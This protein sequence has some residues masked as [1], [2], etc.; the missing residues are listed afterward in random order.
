MLQQLALRRRERRVQV[1]VHEILARAVAEAPRQRVDVALRRRRIGERPRVLVDPERERRRLERRRREL[2]LG[3]DPDERR[4]ERAVRRQHRRLRG[5]PLGK[6]VL[7][8]VVE[9]HLLDV[10][11]ESDRFELAEPRRARH[12]DDD[13]APDRV[14]LE[15]AHLGDGAELLGVQ[16]VEVADVPV[17]RSDGDDGVGIEEARSEHRSER[18]EVGVPVRGDDLLGPHGRILTQVRNRLAPIPA[19]DDP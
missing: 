11:V 16:A 15:A 9:E 2:A 7:A 1:V 18:V 6:L 10:R 4:R 17:Q 13:Q 3:D 19:C 8:V 12:L 14:E 5:H